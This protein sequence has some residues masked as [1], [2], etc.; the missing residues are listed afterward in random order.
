MR[1]VGIEPAA[2]IRFPS[3]STKCGTYEDWQKATGAAL[4]VEQ[5]PHWTLGAAAGFVGPV[6]GLCDLDTCGINLSGPTTRGKTTGVALGVSTWTSPLLTSG[7]LLR[8]MRATQ[9]SI[10]I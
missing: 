9:T 7:G 1:C 5:C 4:D 6:L 10:E 2:E 8:S 3:G